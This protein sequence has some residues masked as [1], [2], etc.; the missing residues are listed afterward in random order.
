MTTFRNSGGVVGTEWGALINCA[1]M[2]WE[3]MPESPASLTR[4]LLVWKVP[5]MWFNFTANFEFC[6]TSHESYALVWILRKGDVPMT[7]GG[8]EYNLL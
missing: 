8:N 2:K 5:S 1:M 7:N 3:K 4:D 6:P